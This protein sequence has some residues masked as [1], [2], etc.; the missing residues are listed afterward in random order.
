MDKNTIVKFKGI[1]PK[2]HDTSYIADGAVVTGDAT[3]KKNAN[4][5]FNSVC[6]CYMHVALKIMHL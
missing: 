5:W 3:I 1:A 6:Q 2:I 4:I